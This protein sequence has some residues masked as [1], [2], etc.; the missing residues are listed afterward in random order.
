VSILH[1]P[2]TF[3]NIAEW[4]RRAAQAINQL[5]TGKQDKDDQLTS[6][7]AL[8]YTGNAAKVI[9]VTAG[10]DGF[11]LVAQAGGGSGIADGDYGDIVVS[12]TGTVLS[13]DTG[14][15]TAFAKTFLDDADA[16]AVRTTLSAAAASHTHAQADVTGLT[17]ADSPQFTGINLGHAS[18]TTLTRVSA[19]VAAIEGVNI[20]TTAGGITFAADISVPDEAY[21]A[22]NWNGSVEVPTKN[23]VRD[24]IEAMS[25]PRG[26]LVKKAAD[27]TAANYVGGAVVAWDSEGAGCYDTDSIHDNV[28][29]NSRLTTPPG[30]THVE[31]RGQIYATS[32]T[33]DTFL[34]VLITK[35]G[36]GDYPG[37]GQDAA[38]IGSTGAYIQAFTA[39]VPVTGGTDYFEYFL[40]SESD[41]SIT[42]EEER[43]W[44]A[45]RV[46]A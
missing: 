42:I 28:T 1:V 25:S 4:V 31:L 14:V 44:F 41:T 15:V 21:D 32:M 20:V 43:S 2:V 22:T 11:E 33:A 40:I 35:N 12:G 29:N 23:A 30:A 5:I 6:L 45:M 24:K 26:A 38:E 19:G 27:Q 36:S 16:A 9:A 34:R 8:E 46:V 13:F 37:A 17:T 39:V 10:E 3:A 18:D 7:A